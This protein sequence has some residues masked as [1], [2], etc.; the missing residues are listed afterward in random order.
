M[1]VLI[2][3]NGGRE[4][5]IAWKLAASPRRPDIVIAPGNAGTAALGVN[6]P[7]DAEDIDGLLKLATD[8]AVDITIVG[9]EAP[10]AA[11]IVDRFNEA[12]LRIFGP[13]AAAARIEASK[14]FAKQVMTSAG[15]PTA[16]SRSFTSLETAER[17]ADE[18]GA[19]LVVKADGLAAGKG[20]IMAPAR[21]DAF[22]ALSMIF[23]DRAFG[24]AGDTVLIEEWMT[25]TEVS[26]FAFVDG[27]YVSDMTAACDYKRALDGDAGPNTGGMGSYS[28]PLI[29]NAELESIVRYQIMEPVAA[30]MAE[31]N[32]PFQGILY[33]GIMVTAQGPKVFEFN[34][35]LGD[36][37]AQVVLPRLKT[38]LLDIALATTDGRLKEQE[39]IWSGDA[40]VGVVMS[41]AGYP[42]GYDTGFEITGLPQ[43]RRV[44]SDRHMPEYKA[45]F[46]AGTTLRNSAVVTSGGRVLTAS[47][48][49]KTLEN[50]RHNAYDLAESIK[51]DNASYRRDIAA[52]I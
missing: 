49:G 36:P 5:A 3:G 37:E 16:A 31:M 35:R 46:H 21:S 47:A 17:Y 41:S 45:V 1:K 40:W 9:P 52:N 15:V 39:V 11:G 27:E 7:I 50:A 30:R 6:A 12:G 24:A 25:G 42:G 33:A 2:V 23:E 43:S 48:S 38:D 26:V 4:H 13:T 51:F 8:Q 32:C 34:C 28:P 14:W 10:L 44:R 19:P 22:A 18:I 29:W 20:V